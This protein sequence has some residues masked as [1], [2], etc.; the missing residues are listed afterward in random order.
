[1]KYWYHFAIMFEALFIL[2]TID[3]GTRVGRF[4]LGEALGRS[5]HKE[6]GRHEWLPGSLLTSAAIAGAWAALISAG[7]ISTIWPMFGVANQLLAC[8]ALC[9]AT[10]ILFNTGKG[11]YAWTTL[12]PL[13]FISVTTLTAGWM[14]VTDIFLP[15]TRDPAR[16]TQGWIDTLLT[17]VLMLA[18]LVVLIASARKWL[19]LR[20]GHPPLPRPPP[21][22][23]PAAGA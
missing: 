7:T 17:A 19:D 23:R 18:A 3:T 2:T 9:V 13:G 11:R 15:M 16:A 21:A 20:H 8:V 12:L 14:S 10:S 6:F 4:L 22:P 5:L 1:M